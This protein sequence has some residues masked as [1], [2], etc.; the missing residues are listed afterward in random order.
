MRAWPSTIRYNSGTHLFSLEQ[1]SQV[2][3]EDAVLD[4]KPDLGRPVRHGRGV[5]GVDG[6]SVV[7]ID[8]ASHVGG[9][10]HRGGRG[11]CPGLQIAF[12]SVTLNSLNF[13]LLWLKYT[14]GYSLPSSL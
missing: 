13:C 7:G 1:F 3:L 10:L 5:E 4:R 11:G 14:W 6:T 8:A 2:C 9:R 12:V